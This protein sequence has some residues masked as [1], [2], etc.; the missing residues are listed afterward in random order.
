M[1]L[2]AGL[3]IR[4]E[5]ALSRGN[6]LSSEI[7]NTPWRLHLGED[8]IPEI[9]AMDA[10]RILARIAGENRLTLFAHYGTDHAGHR[11]S[12]D[13]SVKALERVDA[14]LGGLVPALPPGTL[15]VLVSD[16]GNIEEI[17]K[18]HTRNPSL[19]LLAGRGASAWRMGLRAIT[20]VPGLIL[21]YLSSTT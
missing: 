10:G 13:A 5:E 4:H 7:V 20:D 14:F 2:S 11:D 16:H 9:S 17:G 21:R 15:L 8:R 19:A 6:A 3:L 18:S 1:A 12:M